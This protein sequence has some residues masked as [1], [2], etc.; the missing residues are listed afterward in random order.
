MKFM[1][2]RGIALLITLLFIVAITASI[3]IGLK[4]I[5]DASKELKNQNFMLQSRIV[6]D[7]VLN[8]INNSA[9][10]KNIAKD[11]SISE[12]NDFLSKVSLLPFDL[13]GLHV[14][15]E[16]QS[17][18]S[19][20]NINDLV[21]STGKPNISRVEIL[22]E[23]V[24]RYN[25]NSGFIDLLLDNMG[26]IKEDM[27]YNTPIFNDKPTL[28]RDYIASKKHF[29]EIVGYY[30]KIYNDN[31]VQKIDFDKLLYFSAKKG[32]FIDLNYA[33]P[34]VWQMMLG[35][36]NA[37]ALALSNGSG[38]YATIDDLDLTDVQKERL[39][40]FQTSFFEPFLNVQVKLEQGEQK[41]YIQF[42]YDIKTQKGSNFV[43]EL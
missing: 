1:E 41:T 23:Y 20:F 10:I 32:D 8:I 11:G 36:D 29:D 42:Q 16:I 27:S 37:K 38:T 34:E 22:K 24:S 35:V 26:K 13:N 43:Y 15:I 21:N 31:S 12:L 3:G 14:S 28:F 19:R 4:Q 33:T 6:L 5:N 30:E 9:Q 39:S 17:A 25:I 7:D 2:K 18:R 40:K